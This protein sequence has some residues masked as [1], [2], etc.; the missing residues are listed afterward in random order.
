MRAG[1]KIGA[2]SLLALKLDD[3][4]GMSLCSNPLSYCIAFTSTSLWDSRTSHAQVQDA[5][6]VG[7]RAASDKVGPWTSRP[8]WERY[9]IGAHVTREV[10]ERDILSNYSIVQVMTRTSR[11]SRG[12]RCSSM[13][14]ISKLL[15]P[16]HTDC[17]KGRSLFDCA[18]HRASTRCICSTCTWLKFAATIECLQLSS[19]VLKLT[20]DGESPVYPR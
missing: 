13:A 2:S 17:C 5:L 11:Y 1:I 18:Q 20:D 12:V 7:R 15:P 8:G 14:T 3:R 19:R 6:L 10:G 4:G 16:L 9:E